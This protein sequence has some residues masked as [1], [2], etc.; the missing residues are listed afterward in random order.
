MKQSQFT[1]ELIAY[2]PR[3]VDCAT[4]VSASGCER[5]DVLCLGAEVRAPKRQGE[6]R[7]TRPFGVKCAPIAFDMKLRVE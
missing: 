4:P 2:A 6:A 1:E 7:F 5:Y 3:P